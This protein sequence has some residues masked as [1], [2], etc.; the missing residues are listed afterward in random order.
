MRLNF[1]KARRAMLNED[2][3]TVGATPSEEVAMD[4]IE[5]GR[6]SREFA[7]ADIIREQE[8]EEE[9]E[10]DD[11]D[12]VEEVSPDDKESLEKSVDDAIEGILVDYE[13]NARKSAEL[14][15][16]SRYSLRRYLLTEADDKLDVDMFS[17]DVARLIKNYDTLLDMEAI[18]INKAIQFLEKNYDSDI[19]EEFVELLDV[20]HDISIGED[21]D[22]LE[23]PIAVGAS[24]GGGA[25]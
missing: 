19:A 3:S 18:I 9:E 22:E 6:E 5:A 16:E 2:I 23:Q 4:S 20:R 25:A 24:G 7:E 15:T 11:E 17:S 12:E 8:E 21:P 13:S 14:Q 10:S 1:D